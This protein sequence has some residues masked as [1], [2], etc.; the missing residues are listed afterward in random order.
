MAVVCKKKSSYNFQP[1]YPV[2]FLDKVE[3]VEQEKKTADAESGQCYYFEEG[4]LT[5]NFFKQDIRRRK[6]AYGSYKTQY[7]RH[8]KDA[9]K[10]HVYKWLKKYT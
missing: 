8:I 1:R 10:K 7:L 9:I 2:E 5:S 3:N 6:Y 4:N